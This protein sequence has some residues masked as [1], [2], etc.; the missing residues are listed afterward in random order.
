MSWECPK[1]GKI[2]ARD[3]QGHFCE[4]V[5]QT[6]FLEMC[7]PEVA[8]LYLAFLDHART[9]FEVREQFTRKAVSW[10]A[11]SHKV[12]LVTHHKKRWLDSFY[13]LPD[14]YPEFPVH[15]TLWSMD[16]KRCAHYMRFQEAEDLDQTALNRLAEA[17]EYANS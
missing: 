17:Y 7:T 12:F 13:Y 6:D 5:S 2:F 16:G 15:K 10:Y 11:P 4:R 8:D 1:C 3:N 9:R 14:E